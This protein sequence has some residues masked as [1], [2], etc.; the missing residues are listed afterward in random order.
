VKRSFLK[1]REVA[2]RHRQTAKPGTLFAFT[3][4]ATKGELYIYEVIGEDWWTGGGVTAK[5]VVE[6]LDAM[7]GVKT[8]DVYINSE[9]GDVFEAKAIFENL[10]RFGAEKTVHVDGIAA[11]AATFI[12]MAGDTII[13]APAA[14]W[15]VHEAWSVALGRAEDMRAMADV[16]DME[17]RAIAETYATRTGQPVDEMLALMAA[18]TWMNAR[19]ARDRGFTDEIAR[20]DEGADDEKMAATSRVAVIASQ[21]EARVALAR[22][23]RRLREMNLSRPLPAHRHTARGAASR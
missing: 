7:K 21:T 23:G 3:E 10:K 20:Q 5:K 13:T 17:N 6:A 11:S 18:E 4:N 14:T 15:M 2:Q 12:A 16:L 22:Q 8:L 9:G 19:E 1:A